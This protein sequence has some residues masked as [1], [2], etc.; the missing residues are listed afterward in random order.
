[1]LR[2]LTWLLGRHFDVVYDLHGSLRSRV[3]TLLTQAEVRAGPAPGI[4]YTHVPVNGNSAVPV[5]DRFNQVLVAGGIGPATPVFHLPGLSE[6]EAKVDAWLHTNKLLGKRL[7][8]LHA[9]GSPRWLSKR[10]AEANYRELAAALAHRGLEVVWIGAT[11]ERELNHRLSAVVGV[12]AT[13]QFDHRELAALAAYARFAV[14]SD[15]GPMHLLSI[16]GRP[17]Y[18]FFGPT[19]WRRSHALGQQ[20]RVLTNP[21]LCSPCHLPVCPPE[22][23]HACLDGITPAMVLARLEADRLLGS[24]R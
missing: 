11:A 7:V 17:V 6:V 23:R 20:G 8:L 3:M 14:T 22:R 19:D 21:V 9:G 1:M 4:A 12:D 13:G 15:S 2:V 10:W 16:A 18:A 24:E 5:F